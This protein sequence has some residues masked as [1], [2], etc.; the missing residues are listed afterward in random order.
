MRLTALFTIP[1]VLRHSDAI[2]ADLPPDDA[3]VLDA[4]DSSLRAALAAAAAGDHAPAAE[5]LAGTRRH[6]QWERRDTVV[7]R[8]A[9]ASLHHPGWLDSW[10]EASP[11]DPDAVLVKADQ[12]VYQAWQ[13]RTGARARHVEADQFKAFHAVLR[14]AVP[15][16]SAAAELNPDDP[17]PWRIALTQARGIQ[18]PREVFDTYLAEANERDPH[19]EGCHVQAL[20]YLCAK[21]F[22]SHEEMFAF[23]ERAAEQAPPGSRLH[24]LPLQ[25]VVEY[26]IADEETPGPDPYTPRAEAAVAR[27]QALSESYA[28]GDREA[29]GFRNHLAMV[30]WSMNRYEEALTAFRSIG[31]HA[32]TFPW[33][34][35]GE[36]RAE[37]LEAR[38]DTRVEL[39]MKV[40]F[41]SPSPKPPATGAPDWE[42]ELAP[43]SLA[44]ASTG[45][46]EV[47]QAALICGHSLRT[48]PAGSSHTYVEIVPDPVR[49]K[50]AALLPEDPLT[51]AADNFTTAEDWPA[52]ILHRTPERGSFTLLHRGKKVAEHSWETAA[53]AADHTEATA[54]AAALARV[55]E[56]ADPRPLA[57]ILRA[58]GDP[59]RHQS[60]LVAALGLP[61]LPEGYG[62]EQE[63][64]AGLPGARVLVRR[65]FLAGMRDTLTTRDGVHPG[66]PPPAEPHPARWWVLRGLALPVF[67]AAAVY[68]WWTPDIGWFR[69]TVSSA[70][71]LYVAAQL[72]RAVRRR[73]V[74]SSRPPAAS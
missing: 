48:A 22:G 45:P 37:F 50:R 47:A 69:S 1:R 32:T 27:A 21:W 55:Y 34:Y 24:A 52:L 17:V 42:R 30:L 64:L 2:G 6:A 5:L 33:T 36:A 74:S 65:G 10:L 62:G 18:A 60:E 51:S 14:D 72:L 67:T 73:P 40:P 53:P 29:A 15:V 3:V 11:E 7:S 38:S 63:I 31:V 43:R 9:R 25:A 58:T 44:I 54:N 19:H 20:Q 68:A 56:I 35:F 8:L 49:G 71:A 66:T 46:T 23:A 59:A 4:P 13:I 57:H 61:P 16:I 70:V 28:P 26:L 41:F 39:A 12:Y